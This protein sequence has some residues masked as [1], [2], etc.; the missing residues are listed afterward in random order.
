MS[1]PAPVPAR[2]RGAALLAVLLLVAVTGALAAAAMEKL[3]LSRALAANV[4]ALEQARAFSGGMV[5]LAL[6]TIDDMVAQSPERTTN[7]GGWNGAVRRVP[8]PGGLG[9]AE[10]TVRDG[11]NC[12]NVNSVVQGQPQTGL[13]QRPSGILQ[14]HSLMR[15]LSVPD[16]D[17]QRIANA[18][19][20]WADSDEIA[21]SIGAE[22]AAY[23]A[24]EVPYRA[25]NTLFAEPSEIRAL[26][27]MDARI[28]DK[29]RPWICALPTTDLAPINVNTLAPE[30][31][32][33]LAMLAPDRLSIAEARR[34]IE[35]RP[36]EGWSSQL[37]FWRTESVSDLDPTLDVQL[38]PQV[39]TRWFRIELRT[40]AMGSEFRETALVD[41]RLQ[42]ARVVSRRWGSE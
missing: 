22:D 23:A 32:P 37:D 10:G 18:A 7:A 40:E 42:P 35:S 4:T 21:G 39:R 29:V 6:L 33:L 8:L 15:V 3:R 27:G 25:G 17:A 36:A 9:V 31:A 12:F 11:G 41:A 34:V 1:G 26:A 38:Q 2:E 14:F 20:D 5:E 28:W 24:G 13:T 19:A 16:A 30:Q